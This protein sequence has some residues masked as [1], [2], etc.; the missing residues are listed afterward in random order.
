MKKVTNQIE[1]P[2]TWFWYPMGLDEN[3][4]KCSLLIVHAC[5]LGK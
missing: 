3:P 4:P 2:I 1:Y 5:L